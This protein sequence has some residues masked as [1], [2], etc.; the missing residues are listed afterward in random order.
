MPE[1]AASRMNVCPRPTPITPTLIFFVALF[2]F[3]M[4]L[5]LSRAIAWPFENIAAVFNFGP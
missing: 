3:L 1:G 5:F 2:L 4:P